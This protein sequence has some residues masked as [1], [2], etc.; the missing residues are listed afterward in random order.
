[1]KQVRYTFTLSVFTLLLASCSKFLDVDPKE[2]VS[3]AQTI[4][5]K[6]S[7]EEAVNGIY[8]ALSSGDYYG[9][10][11][12]S[13]GYLSGDNVQWTGSQ[14]QIQEFINHNVRAENATISGAWSAIYRTINRANQVLTKVPEVTDPQ[15]TPALKDQ[16][17]GEAYFIRALAYFDLAR[18]WG[19]APLI[20]SPT[21]S[22]TDNV[23]IPRSTQAQ[24]YA[25]ALSDL[26]AAEPLLPAT[27]N[28][29]RATKNCMGIEG[30]VLS[31]QPRLA[32]GG[33]ICY[34]DH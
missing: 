27:T 33:G 30:P 9:T 4:F 16:L 19:G 23:G 3:D 26:E 29:Y 2:S 22:V 10:G 7:A 24:T 5:D 6:T 25:Q 8:S 21:S 11:F 17:L 20:T 14:S 31:L 12:Q 28:R 32:E 1:M 15:L 13:I 34:Q 18:T